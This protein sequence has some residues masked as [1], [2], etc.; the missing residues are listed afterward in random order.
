MNSKT[1][2]ERYPERLAFELR[3][4]EAAGFTYEKDEEAFGV[5]IARFTVF[6]DVG[7]TG[8]TKLVVTF[9]DFYP[10]F[11]FTIEAPDLAL[12]HH[13][14]PF[15]KNLCVLGRATELW[16]TT[17]TVAAFITERVPE[18]IR[19]GLSKTETEVRGSEEEQAEPYSDYYSYAPA[20]LTIDGAWKIPDAATFGTLTYGLISVAGPNLWIRGVVLEVRDQSGETVAKAHDQVRARFSGRVLKGRWVRSDEPV[21]IDDPE[22]F[23]EH[24]ASIDPDPTKIKSDTVGNSSVKLRA[25]L[26]PEEAAWRTVGSQG[27]VFAF[28]TVRD[29]GN[30]QGPDRRPGK[31]GINNP[32]FY[33]ARAGRAGV[34]DL[35]ERAP[36]LKGLNPL[37]VAVF[38]VGCIG[39]PSVLEFARAG[40]GTLRL[41]DFDVVDP[42]TAIRW[43]LGL[44]AAGDLKVEALASFLAVHYPYCNVERIP[45]VL[46]GARR[47]G[48]CEVELLD[49]IV[50]DT[51]LIYDATAEPGIQY[52]LSEYARELEIPY[53]GVSGTQGGWGGRIVRIRPN[54]TGGCWACVEAARFAGDYPEP[55]A[56]DSKPIQPIGCANPTFTGTGFDMANLAMHGVRLSVSTLLAGADGAYPN[57]N[58]DLEIIAFRGNDG[59]EIQADVKTF[60]LPRHA[61]CPACSAREN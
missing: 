3:A 4:L 13:Q 29:L 36:E 45:M 44:A 55:P 25:V 31:P 16:R 11:R 40:V 51:S 8:P 59:R 47:A 6:A 43:P 2:W 60:S 42:A 1:W 30:R 26:F 37:T 34:Q 50:S 58:W 49:K 38:G 15:G 28:R 57:A 17:D 39:A 10:F 9:P 41:V 33:L 32:A 27:W 5:G 56:D 7:L 61:E 52:F 48:P 23:F 21:P 20:M 22:K 12:P 18:V 35:E 24:L 19:A 46:G 54:V 14:H 53:I